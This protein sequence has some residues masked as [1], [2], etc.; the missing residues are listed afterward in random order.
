MAKSIIVK[1]IPPKSI[2]ETKK[3]IRECIKDNEYNLVNKSSDTIVFAF[4]DNN[5][6]DI[7][8][9]IDQDYVDR[10]EEVLKYVK[11]LLD[12]TATVEMTDFAILTIDNIH[13]HLLLIQEQ[14]L[15]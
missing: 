14:V 2:N 5:T 13:S 12:D 7:N 3:L 6:N 8:I 15:Y 10:A 4:Y 1:G 11:E 9:L